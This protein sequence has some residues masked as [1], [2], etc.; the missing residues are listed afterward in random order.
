MQIASQRRASS[1]RRSIA[2][3]TLAL[4]AAAF[5]VG[6]P[7]SAQQLG[8][9]RF[10]NWLY[11]QENTDNSERWQYRPR[12]FIPFSLPRGWTFTQRADLPVYYT[13]KVGPE[14]PGG[15]WKSGHRRLVHRGD[16]RHP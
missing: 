9:I 14:N 16:L 11:F 2:T 6:D 5:A 12:F 15:D 1:A 13:N 7:A 3:L 10:D 4:A 8:T